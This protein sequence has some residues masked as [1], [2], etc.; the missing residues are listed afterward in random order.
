MFIFQ[1][2][3]TAVLAGLVAG[4]TLNIPSRSGSIISLPAPSVI[5]GS[6]DF[7]NKE[8]DCGRS[9]NTDVETPSGHPVFVLEN[10]AAI[11]NVIIGA[12]QVEGVHC[13]GACTLKNVWFR[14]ACE[15]A[16]VL[17]GNGDILVEGG[18]VRGGAGNTISHL[19]R[20]T[21]TVKDFTAVNVNRLY[22]SC[23]N[24][25]NN[26]GPRNLA[27]TNLKA[28]NVKLLAG[29]NSNF[30]DIATVSGSCGAGI[31]KVCQEYKAVEK[32]QE[33][34]KVTTTANCNGQTSLDVC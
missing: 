34:P 30:G 5:S 21:A 16:I 33:S 28:N 11:S 22:R 3:S 13:R 17:N 9:C 8:Y 6:R 24:C 12:G 7:G 19:G 1:I 23:A 26:G 2:M 31:T 25:A 18:G 27:V 4:Q 10:G 15:D 14:Q 32:G 29:I 20:G